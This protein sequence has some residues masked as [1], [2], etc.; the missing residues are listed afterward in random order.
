MVKIRNYKPADYVAV[1]AN[2][3]PEDMFDEIWDSQKSY[4]SVISIDPDNIQVAEVDGKVVGSVM[5]DQ[6]GG[7]LAFIYRLVVNKDYRGRGIANKLLDEVYRILRARG[8]KEV[9]LFANSENEKLSKFYAK[10]GYAKGTNTY[11]TFW[12]SVD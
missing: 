7:D 6:M 11:R 1:V 8:T 12:K 4:D 10:R 5:I 9:A 2:L 3:K